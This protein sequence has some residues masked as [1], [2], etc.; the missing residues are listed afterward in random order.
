MDG[1]IN[2]M[3]ATGGYRERGVP[4][5]DEFLF[6]PLGG[7]GEIGMNM[8]LYGHD[9]AWLMVDCGISF[10]DA[11]TPGVEVIMPDPAFIVERRDALCG[12]VL[13]HAHEDHLGAVPYLWR[14]LGR[15][16]IH[17][18]PFTACVLR[19]K[20]QEAGL[21]AEVTIIEMPLSGIAT[22]GPFTVEL[23]TLTHSIPEPNALILRT[24]VGS[25]L[26]T[27]DWKL[28]PDPLV[29]PTADEA[30]LIRLGEE[31]ALAMVCDSTNALEA[32]RSGSEGEVRANLTELIGGLSGGVALA[33]FASNIAR[34][35]SGA[36]AALATGRTPALVGRSLW[37]MQ[38]AAREAGY[39][40]DVPA[41]LDPEKA[42]RLPRDKIL[43]ICTGSQGE[44]RAALSRIARGDHPA[45][46]LGH[47]DTV[48]FSSR[49]IPG[50]EIAIGELQNNLALLG[51][52]VVTDG[53]AAIHTSGHPN[54]D[55]LAD[56]YGWV[57]P[58]IAVPVHGEPRH[59][60]AHAKLARDCQVPHGIVA[61]NGLLMGLHTDGV[62]EM[63]EVYAGRL[64]L[65]GTMLA[66]AGDAGV[67]RRRQMAW[68]GH[69][70][71]SVAL[72]HTGRLADG[73]QITLNGIPRGP[74]DA[75]HDAD[76]HAD[77]DHVPD[78][79]D[80]A[81]YDNNGTSLQDTLLDAVEE[82][83]SRLGR[84]KAGDD[85][86]VMEAVRRALRRKLRAA[87]GKRPPVD[88][89]VLRV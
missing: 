54:R 40:R 41:F 35:E 19:R 79:D 72:D 48:I 22:V 30:R 70:V 29:G 63:D 15:P 56:M 62:E 45:I 36:L 2:P 25:V 34:L 66:P 75:D 38:D 23:V 28:D 86:A 5:A 58:R 13:T 83:V 74:N 1:S 43:L 73:A 11:R 65:D 9:G 85:H 71:V 16:V 46:N 10:G 52:A 61:H 14:R 33:C 84:G 21:A 4:G 55:E 42:T 68:N 53:A 64:L 31:G 81:N 59:L 67:R 44:P 57:K 88:V 37:R 47:G 6:L 24:P 60:T 32:G 50:N 27:G 7:T 26:H 77:S 89:H 8:N 51:C 69:V 82:A 78:D 17:A 49:E 87:T 20:L 39:L 3:R 12:L 76:N 80:D 18:T